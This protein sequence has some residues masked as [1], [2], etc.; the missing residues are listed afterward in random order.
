MDFLRILRK[1]N[2][3]H[4]EQRLAKEKKAVAETRFQP[5]EVHELRQLFLS[6][7]EDC[8]GELS[9]DE[10]KSMIAV[11]CPMG[12]KNSAALSETFYQMS[13]NQ[14]GV[15]GHEDELDFPEFLWFLKHLL[16]IDFGKIRQNVASWVPKS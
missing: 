16:D 1:L 6:G 2:D 13:K 14:W 15:N 3:I 12:D 11:I 10:F 5:H 8:N 4:K 9:L 7:D